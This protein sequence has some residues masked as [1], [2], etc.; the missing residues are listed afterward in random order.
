MLLEFAKTEM[1]EMKWKQLFEK[2][3]D[4]EKE[5]LKLKAKQ[6]EEED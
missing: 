3:S 4:P 2:Y 6:K 1:F 5:K